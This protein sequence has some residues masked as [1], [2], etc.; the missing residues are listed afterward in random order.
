MEKIFYAE[1][2]A[3]PNSQAALTYILEKYFALPSA[4][5]ARTENG[6][7]YLENIHSPL[8]FS[9]SHTKT[10]L[11]IAF[12]DENVGIDAEN[13]SRQVDL[14]PLLKRFPVEERAEIGSTE[15]FLRH[16][17]AKEAAVKWLGGKLAHDLRKLAY[18]QGRLRYE[19]LELPVYLTSLRIGDCLLSVCSE[20]DFSE[21]ELIQV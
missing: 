1:L 13:G 3:Y 12:C 18:I 7:P 5:L 2:S 19:Q 15:D 16:W 14:P 4:R 6:K 17:T 8:H 20:R 21:A 9:V 11:F 10:R